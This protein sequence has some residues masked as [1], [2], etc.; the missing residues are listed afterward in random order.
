MMRA[1]TFALIALACTSG[2]VR[3]QQVEA[4]TPFERAQRLMASGDGMAARA[5]VDSALRASPP[6]TPA[7]AEALYWRASFAPTAAEAEKDYLRISVEYT[8]SG[9]AD[10]ALF[11]LAQLELVRGDRT[12]GVRHLQRLLREHPGGNNEARAAFELA[13]TLFDMNDPPRACGAVAIARAAVQ[14]EDVE[15]RNRI[16]YLESRCTNVTAVSAVQGLVRDVAPAR[17]PARPVRADA[18]PPAAPPVTPP[19]S[20]AAVTDSIVASTP[21]PPPVTG[22]AFSVQVAAF[23]KRA[24]ADALVAVLEQRGFTARV[25]GNAAP[26]RVRTGRVATRAEAEKILEALRAARIDGMVVEAEPQ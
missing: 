16:E 19:A 3:A 5:L 22:P 25:W 20:A 13:R 8:L 18:P 11:R 7:Y 14:A 1:T 26:Y 10:D 9:R 12:G 21:M 24:Q 15:L 4:G 6:G 2:A 23:T 17:P